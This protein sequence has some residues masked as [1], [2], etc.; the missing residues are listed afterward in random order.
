M[1]KKGP[2]LRNDHAKGRTF[3]NIK[4]SYAK[5]MAVLKGMICLFL[6]PVTQIFA[7]KYDNNHIKPP[8]RNSCYYS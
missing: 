6:I 5:P 3:V 7:N 1:T 4:N 2:S 8:R